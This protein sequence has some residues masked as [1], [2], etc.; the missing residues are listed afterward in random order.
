MCLIAVNTFRWAVIN[1]P[2]KAI[3]N[4][5]RNVTKTN[6]MNKINTYLLCGVAYIAII[7]GMMLGEVG[8]LPESVPANPEPYSFYLPVNGFL[9][10]AIPFVLGILAGRKHYKKD[11][12]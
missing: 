10:V 12:E 3:A 1:S 9:L 4:T 5:V 2:T 6:N 7:T 8:E 11:G